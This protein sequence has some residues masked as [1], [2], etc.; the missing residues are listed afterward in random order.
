MTEPNLAM[1]A[2]YILAAIGSF[3]VVASAI[4]ESRL[5]F[6]GLFAK[7]D[8]TLERGEQVRIQILPA[9]RN[10]APVPNAEA[11]GTS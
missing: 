1:W 4:A 7:L 10:S 3:S 6:Q 2:V 8:E 11:W 9:A 5:A